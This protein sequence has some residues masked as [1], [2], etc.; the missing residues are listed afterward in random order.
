MNQPQ[1]NPAETYESY[2][3]PAMFQ[4]WATIL[5]RHAAL[6]SG[7]R[8]LDVACGTGVVAR[9]AAPLVGV[10]G[11]VAAID[12]NS[13]MVAV[14]RSLPAPSGASIAWHDGDAA[15][16]PF[17]DGV[18]DVVLCQHALPFFPDRAAAAR[19]MHRVLKSGG[20]AMTIV[21][22]RLERHVVFQAL[23]ESV[24]RHLVVP[25]SVVQIPFALCDTDELRTLYTAVG[26]DEVEI[27]P[28][29]TMV[30]FPDAENFVPLAVMSSAAAVPAFAQLK[31]PAKAA[32]VEAIRAEI[33]PTIQAHK[34][35]DVISFPMFAHVAVAKA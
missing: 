18:F 14:A 11:Q 25:I 1:P 21:L 30:R 20:R 3:V 34:S 29:S 15:A 10:D 6:R 33:E 28:E 7:E 5:L 19:E 12:M 26:F 24:A 16:L 4:P 31:G 22:Q 8:V 35:A 17:A 23:M 32:M 27:R 13:A 2:F 9:L